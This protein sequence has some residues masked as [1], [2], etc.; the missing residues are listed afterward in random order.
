MGGGLELGIG[1]GLGLGLGIRFISGGGCNPE[2]KFHIYIDFSPSLMVV[3]SVQRE[4]E[5]AY[6]SQRGRRNLLYFTRDIRKSSLTLGLYKL[7]PIL[8]APCFFTRLTNVSNIHFF[9]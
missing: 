1:L 2:I 9:F 4:K 8:Q 5:R 6:R 3:G 7:G